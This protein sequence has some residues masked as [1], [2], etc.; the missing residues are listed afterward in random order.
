MVSNQSA[1]QT[2]DINKAFSSTQ[3]LL[4]FF[5]WDTSSINHKEGCTSENIPVDRHWKT[6][7]TDLNHLS[8][9]FWLQ[10]VVF[11]TS[12]CLHT[13]SCCRLYFG[14]NMAKNI[15]SDW[16]LQLKHTVCIQEACL[17]YAFTFTI[18]CFLDDFFH[19]MMQL[20]CLNKHVQ[21]LIK[22]FS[23]IGKCHQASQILVNTERFEENHTRVIKAITKL[24]DLHRPAV[25][26]CLENVTSTMNDE[27]RIILQRSKTTTLSVIK[28]KWII[29]KKKS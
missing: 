2:L 12:T 5:F 11:T 22:I 20:K 27:P 21:K 23:W 16:M 19:W 28:C 26:Y 24:S 25:S 18:F 14:H 17:P 6:S 15:A 29:K 1:H 13:L 3:L 8:S 9:P 7:R 4:F 10:E